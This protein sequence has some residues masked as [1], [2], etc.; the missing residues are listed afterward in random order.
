MHRRR[1]APGADPGFACSLHVSGLDEVR[2]A[3]AGGPASAAA[4]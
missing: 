4:S 3:R 1:D 2:V